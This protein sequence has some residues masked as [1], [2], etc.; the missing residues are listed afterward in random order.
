MAFDVRQ[1]QKRIMAL[2]QQNVAQRLSSFLLDLMEY[3]DFYEP[4]RCQLSL[5]LTRFDLADYL[6]TTPETVV[7][8]LARLEHDGLIRRLTARLL[9]IRDADGLARLLEERRRTG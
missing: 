4:Q 3:S 2:G 9:E 8:I 6:G 1:A 5:Q 7:R